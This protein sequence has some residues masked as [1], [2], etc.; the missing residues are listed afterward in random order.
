VCELG[1]GRSGRH[2]RDRFL[3]SVR[4][5]SS[6]A[7]GFP[8]SEQTVSEVKDAVAN[9][10]FE[11]SHA[12]PEPHGEV[13][14]VCLRPRM[15]KVA[16]QQK[17]FAEGVSSPAPCHSGLP[18]LVIQRGEHRAPGASLAVELAETAAMPVVKDGVGD[19]LQGYPPELHVPRECDV[20]CAR[21]LFGEA[22]HSLEDAPG[23]PDAAA[24]EG[25]EP[26]EG[27][28]L[29][30]RRRAVGSAPCSRAGG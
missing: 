1:R 30:L 22:S 28:N 19:E 21:K 7:S 23:Y 12:V 5:L 13:R 14:Q 2:A 24:R 20:L 29:A 4:R 17:P 6:T 26:G 16:R 9:A 25:Q 15:E 10:S 18:V 3:R 8:T 11:L 27:V